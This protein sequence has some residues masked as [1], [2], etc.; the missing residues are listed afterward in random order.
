[1]CGLKSIWKLIAGT[2]Q[3]RIS[4]LRETPCR[5]GFVWGHINIFLLPIPKLSEFG[6]L[7]NCAPT[8]WC[9]C[10]LSDNGIA[11][12][13]IAAWAIAAWA[14]A[15]G[16]I[17]VGA[18]A[19]GAIGSFALGDYE[20][21]MKDRM[22]SI[23]LQSL[24]INGAR[25]MEE[26]NYVSCMYSWVPPS[27]IL[28]S[29]RWPWFVWWQASCLCLASLCL[30]KVR[31]EGSLRFNLY[32]LFKFWRICGSTLHSSLL[33]VKGLILC[34][35]WCK[36]LGG[37][38]NN[39]LGAA[40]PSWRILCRKLSY[41]S[42]L[43]AKSFSLVC[44]GSRSCSWLQSCVAMETELLKKLSFIFLKSYEQVKCW[45]LGSVYSRNFGLA[46]LLVGCFTS[47][48]VTGSYIWL[49]LVEQAS[50]PALWLRPASLW[51]ELFR[52]FGFGGKN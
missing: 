15:A 52:R 18:I 2:A 14:I 1:M 11:L 30:L 45:Y 40:C 41:F 9:T 46:A 25:E 28:V 19:G 22:G 51:S 8:G 32:F 36:F 12:R 26:T 39:S 13:K 42:Y 31:V 44:A 33:V 38:R 50:W 23:W 5:F 6:R 4:R 35:L 3:G 16:A 34:A 29:W 10:K 49:V 24:L 37:G 47:G 43:L 20:C 7:G 27:Q 17:A 48:R 21:L